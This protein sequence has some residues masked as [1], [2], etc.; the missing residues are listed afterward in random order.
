MPRIHKS[1][2]VLNIF[3]L[4]IVTIMAEAMVEENSKMEKVD[5]LSKMKLYAEE[6]EYLKA[7]LKRR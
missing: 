6:G 1:N 7:H 3:I 5:K 2:M 4:V